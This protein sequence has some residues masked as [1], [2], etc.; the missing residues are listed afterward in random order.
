MSRNAPPPDAGGSF[1]RSLTLFDGVMLVAGVMIGSGIFIVSADIARTVGGTGWMMLVW[2]LGGFMTVVAALSYG[3]LSGMY[4]G[5]G[6]QYVYLR[7]AYNPLIAFLYGWA[8]FTVIQTGLIAVV[9]VAFAKYAA[10]IFPWLGEDIPLLSLG[11]FSISVAQALAILM[12]VFLTWVNSGSIRNGKIIQRIFTSAKILA[13]V[14]LVAAGIFLGARAGIWHANWADAW[15]SFHYV[16]TQVDGK[17][18]STAVPHHGLLLIAMIGVAMVG[19]LFSSDAWNS[20]TF[21]AAEIK[22]PHRNV[23]LSLLLGTFLV[24]VI[25]LLCNLVYIAALPIKE[26]AF[27][28]AD[29]V[30]AAASLN[31]FGPYGAIVIA[32]MI[33]ISTFGCDNGIVLSGARVY[34]AMANDGL[35]FKRAGRLNKAGVPAYGLWIQCIWASVLCISGRYSDLLNYIIFVV[36]IFYMLTIAGIFIL[37]KKYPDMP[38]PYRAVGYPVLPVIYILMGM[39]VCI[40]LLIYRPL[41]TWPGLIIVLLGVPVYYLTLRKTRTS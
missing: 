6:G 17:A 19:S 39:V 7:E 5:A 28:P 31:I 37:R 41:Y 15:D 32:A 24:T 2:V 11:G 20:V 22:N 3:E 38:R 25:Y 1:R 29:R 16:T 23:G 4:P 18:V 8:L 34:Y 14:F 21:I 27:A 9:A 10:Y 12:I 26:I 30:A 40:S 13:M 36:L 35:F 33:M